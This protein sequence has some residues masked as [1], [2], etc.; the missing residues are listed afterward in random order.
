MGIELFEAAKAGDCDQM[1]YWLDQGA[2]IDFK[3]PEWKDATPLF[4]AV[5]SGSYAAVSLLVRRGAK[6][7]AFNHDGWG[8]IHMASKKLL[9]AVI[10]MLLSAGASSEPKCLE[11]AQSQEEAS[12]DKMKV[13]SLLEF[14]ST[15][16][17]VH[18]QYSLPTL[19]AQEG[20]ER[21]L[22]IQENLLSAYVSLDVERVR[23]L[24]ESAYQLDASFHLRAPITLRQVVRRYGLSSERVELICA[25][26][27]KEDLRDEDDLLATCA[28]IIKYAVEQGCPVPISQLFKIIE[29][30]QDDALSYELI[31][32]IAHRI[33]QESAE[34]LSPDEYRKLNPLLNKLDHPAKRFFNGLEK[35][36]VDLDGTVIKAP[37][38]NKTIS[39][40]SK[41]AGSSGSYQKPAASVSKQLHTVKTTHKN[42]Q[43]QEARVDLSSLIDALKSQHKSNQTHRQRQALPSFRT[44]YGDNRSWYHTTYRQVMSF[45]KDVKNGEALKEDDI[46]RYLP[47]KFLKN[48]EKW[49]TGGTPTNFFVDRVICKIFCVAS[50]RQ[51]LNEVSFDK[52]LQCVGTMSEVKRSLFG[53]ADASCIASR[54]IDSSIWNKGYSGGFLNSDIVSRPA[55]RLNADLKVVIEPGWLFDTRRYV[56]QDTQVMSVIESEIEA[57]RSE[58]MTAIYHSVLRK[59][60]LLTASGIEIV[61]RCLSSSNKNLKKMASKT[62]DALGNADGIDYQSLF[63]VHLSQLEET[64]DLE[65]IEELLF[66]LSQPMKNSERASE[67]FNEEVIL[68]I[69]KCLDAPRLNIQNKLSVLELINEYM[70]LSFIR[71]L[72]KSHLD[73]L[74]KIIKEIGSPEITEAGLNILFIQSSKSKIFPEE[75]V[76]ALLSMV[77]G[78]NPRSQNLLVMLL[79]NLEW[80]TAFDF[81]QLA[82]KLLESSVA[83]QDLDGI[84]FVPR[85]KGNQ[86]SHS[87]DMLVAK[88]IADALQFGCERK[89][90]KDTLKYLVSNVSSGDKRARPFSARALYLA[91]KNVLIDE[92]IDL[93]LLLEVQSS[94][95]DPTPDIAVY[96]TCFYVHGLR[97]HALSKALL[98]LAHL[99]FLAQVYVTDELRLNEADYTQQV[100]A[101][102][103][104]IIRQ[105][106]SKKRKLEDSI[107]NIFVASFSLMNGSE[108]ELFK[109]WLLILH[110]QLV[111]NQYAVPESVIE[112]LENHLMDSD[113]HDQV[114]N[115]LMAA[116]RNRQTVS[117][118]TLIVFKDI[119]FKSEDPARRKFV[120]ECLSILDLHQD[121]PTS[122]FAVLEMEKAANAIATGLGNQ[123]EAWRLLENSVRVEEKLTLT[124]LDVLID[125]KILNQRALAIFKT[126]VA[127][128]QLLPRKVVERLVLKFEFESGQYQEEL[129]EIFFYLLRNHQDLP[130]AVFQDL[131]NTLGN[132]EDNPEDNPEGDPKISLSMR[133]KILSIFLLKGQR[134][135]LLSFNVMN[136]LVF[137][138]S[139]KSDDFFDAAMRQACLDSIGTML[140][141]IDPCE[142]VLYAELFWTVET[143]L[144][145]CL[146]DPQP[147]SVRSC[148]QGLEILKAKQGL[149]PQTIE[150]LIKLLKTSQDKSLREPL[151]KL[152]ESDVLSENQ[153]A[154]LVLFCLN[155]DSDEA[156][157]DQCVEHAQKT[158]L[159][160][161]N[162]S[163]ISKIIVSREDL[164]ERALELLSRCN[165]LTELPADLMGHV[166]VLELSSM[167]PEVTHMAR[168]ILEKMLPKVGP[169]DLVLESSEE[170]LG[171]DSFIKSIEEEEITLAS[172]QEYKSRISLMNSE[173]LNLSLVLLIKKLRH[174]EFSESMSQALLECFLLALDYDCKPHISEQVFGAYLDCEE[175]YLRDLAFEGFMRLKAKGYTSE[176]FINYCRELDESITEETGCPIEE[177][178]DLEVLHA[179]ASV[180][181]LS[182]PVGLP[183]KDWIKGLIF[184]DWSERWQL[185][186]SEKISLYQAWR[187]KEPFF[188]RPD[189]MLH[190]LHRQQSLT[191]P[192]LMDIIQYG[193][194][195]DERVIGD[196][197]ASPD[198]GYHSLR[199]LWLKAMLLK[200]IST[201][202]LSLL[203]KAFI[204]QFINEMATQ[205]RPGVAEKL[206]TVFQASDSI[207]ELN[208]LLDFAKRY[209]ISMHHLDLGLDIN[210]ENSVNLAILK[211]KLQVKLL[212]QDF[213]L[214]Y[215]G[216]LEVIFESL[217]SHGWNFDQLQE[218]INIC[219]I[220]DDAMHQREIAL[221]HVLYL[222]APY[223]LSFR[224]YV[225]IKEIFEKEDCASWIKLVNL[226]VVAQHFSQEPAM[227]TS[228]QLLRDFV[229]DNKEDSF[230]FN[231][232]EN[233]LLADIDFINNPHATVSDFTYQVNNA[234]GLS[235]SRVFSCELPVSQWN[236]A[237]ILSWAH[238]V[239]ACPDYFSDPVCLVQAIAV[240]KQTNYLLTGFHLTNTQILACLAALKSEEGAGRFL[241][242]Q[243]GEGKTLIISAIAILKALQGKK[244][245][246]ITSSPVEAERCAREQKSLYGLFGISV[247]DN[248]DRAIYV[249]GPKKCYHSDV[250][251]GEISQ[252]QF[253]TLR[254]EYGLLGTKAGRACEEMV[255][256][257]VDSL[258]I[259]D[260]TKIAKL[261]SPVAGIDQLQPAYYF[262]YRR[263]NELM[264]GQPIE[265]DAEKFIEKNLRD[266]F[267][268]L[269]KQGLIQIPVNFEE[270][271]EKQV[272]HWIKNALSACVEF[273]EEAHYLVRDQR[274]KPVAFDSNGTVQ[275]STYWGDGLHQFLQLKHE[276]QLTSESSTTNFL[277]NMAY[278]KRYGS[279]MCGLTG[280][281][282]SKVARKNLSRVYKVE[283]IEVPSARE[284]QYKEL[285]AVLSSNKSDWMSEVCFETLHELKK[286]RGVLIICKTID[287]VTS[288]EAHIKRQCQSANIKTYTMDG[289]DQ[290]KAI[291]RILPGDII[292]A[293][294]LAGRGFDIKADAINKFGG[295]HVISTYMLDDRNDNQAKY[296][297]SRKGN[298][299]TGRR[300]LNT[301]TLLSN[302]YQPED[303]TS[304]SNLEAA[305][306]RYETLQLEHLFGETLRRVDLKDQLF[307]KFLT[308]ISEIRLDI[309][310]KSRG[311]VQDVI[312]GTRALLS[313][314]PPSVYETTIVAAIEE[315]WA[316]FLKD[317][318]D[319]RISPELVRS[320]YEAFEQRIREQYAAGTVIQNPCH[321]I[322]LGNDLLANGPVLT[323][324]SGEA[325]AHFKAAIERDLRASAGAFIGKAWVYLKSRASDDDQKNYKQLAIE[326]FEKAMKLLCD[327]LACLHNLQILMQDDGLNEN[328][329]LLKQLS[330]KVGL[331]GSHIQ[332]LEAAID[333]I[334]RSQRLMTLTQFKT[335]QDTSPG[336][337][338]RESITTHDIEKQADGSLKFPLEE[339]AKYAV[340]FHDLTAR[341]DMGFRDQAINTISSAFDGEGDDK[342]GSHYKGI[343]LFVPA[344]VDLASMQDFLNPNIEFKQLSKSTAL[345]KL[346]AE[347]SLLNRM[348]GGLFGGSSV[349]VSV[350]SADATIQADREMSVSEAIKLVE[351][352]QEDYQVS[353]SF[354]N[355][356]ERVKSV[357]LIFRGLS[358]EAASLRLQALHH[359][360]VHVSL[361]GN[362]LELL[363][364]IQEES[365]FAEL[366]IIEAKTEQSFERAYKRDDALQII[367]AS[368]S[369]SVSI[370]LENMDQ[371]T[372]DY[373]FSR[374]KDLNLDL[375]ID[376]D[377]RD[378]DVSKSLPGLKEGE[379]EIHFSKLSKDKA[380]SLI[381]QLRKS[382]TEFTTGFDGLSGSQVSRLIQKTERAQEKE[383]IE[384]SAVRSLSTLFAGN[385]LPELELAELSNRGLE[386]ILEVNERN[387]I[388][389]YSIATVC[390]LATIQ[391][392]AGAALMISGFGASVGMGLITEGIADFAT[393]IKAGYTRHFTWR[394][395]VHQKAISLVIAAATMG[396]QS[397]KNAGRAVQNIAIG[398]SETVLAQAGA[399]AAESGRSVGQTLVQRTQQ[400]KSVVFPYMGA[401]VAETGAREVLNHAVNTLSR[402]CFQNFKPKIAQS[403]YSHVEVKFCDT[404]LKKLM[405]KWHVLDQIRANKALSGQIEFTI[406]NTM[407][408]KHSFWLKQWNAVGLPLVQGI[409]SAPQYLGSRFSMGLRVLGL[410]QGSTEILTV[411][412]YFHRHVL[413]TLTTIDRES[414]SIQ[415]L[416][417][418]DC[419][420]TD[421]ESMAIATLLKSKGVIIDDLS[422]DIALLNTVEFGA[423]EQY[424]KPVLGFLSALARGME[425]VDLKPT[426][427][428]IA[429]LMADHLIMVTE[430]QL[431]APV[432]SYLVASGVNSLS[433]KAQDAMI[434]SQLSS[435]IDSINGELKVL[436]EKGASLTG[437]DRN[438]MAAMN[439]DLLERAVML[440]GDSRLTYAGLTA[441][442]AEKKTAAHSRC[443][444]AFYAGAESA[445]APSS[446]AEKLPSDI[447]AYVDGVKNKE[448]ADLLVMTKMKT[449]NKINLKIVDESYCG[450]QQDR[451]ENIKLAVFVSG[452]K[453]PETNVVGI[454][455]WLLKDAEG[456]VLMT[457][458]EGNDCGY[459]VIAELT[460]KSIQDLRRETAESIVRDQASFS[461]AIEARDW[462]VSHNPQAANDLLFMGGKK[463]QPRSLKLGEP[464]L[465]IINDTLNAAA[466]VYDKSVKTIGDLD[467]VGYCY[468]KD[469]DTHVGIYRNRNNGNVIVAFE[470]T[471]FSS[472]RSINDG[473]PILGGGWPNSTQIFKTI[474]S[475]YLNDCPHGS[476]IV[477][478]GHSKGALL[479]S[480]M[481]DA[482]G[483]PA[484]VYDNPG[485][486]LTGYYVHP[487]SGERRYIFSQV[488]SLQAGS[489]IERVGG[490]NK[491]EV[492]Y[493]KH[494]Q[495]SHKLKNIRKDI[496]DHNSNKRKI[497]EKLREKFPDLCPSLNAE[498]SGTGEVVANDRNNTDQGGTSLTFFN[499]VISTSVVS[500]LGVL[501]RN[502]QKC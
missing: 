273:Q 232:V 42:T 378:I 164:Q 160:A 308:L 266:Y 389:W 140:E 86:L 465:G 186:S 271:V 315:P 97:Q 69:I 280:T 183:R 207:L 489:V 274:V 122:V 476:N 68:R 408:P 255:G 120:F 258:L 61:N 229:K 500:Q 219:L 90:S 345:E 431:V 365:Q 245:D 57:M 177:P 212:S 62:L 248:L 322:T 216:K 132:P 469:Y 272:S 460:G 22:S 223:D 35:V 309:R 433:A 359:Q 33:S 412:D 263:L 316:M 300:I 443:S 163:R 34:A 379:A 346:K 213:K 275:N 388:P 423:Y 24:I 418:Q 362:K 449:D 304:L 180:E 199:L 450:T 432:T 290:E 339:T 227:K 487:E 193:A 385:E 312:D 382:D 47:E 78:L 59:P 99:S 425:S 497:A 131:E 5:A 184:S 74:L 145:D 393:A 371:K 43:Q 235:E 228:G 103:L 331:L 3:N 204:D 209:E 292:I 244:V 396:W 85:T 67:L 156:Y 60:S 44:G 49:F 159:L 105:E 239:K 220:K 285:P 347:K 402:F 243:T 7:S 260:S 92:N 344:K 155:S 375:I 88:I 121:L 279:R 104:E 87:I 147:H 446:P 82:F 252:F 467:R 354:V 490:D 493:L 350:A 291:E 146:N 153:R 394:D 247:S 448:P 436:S 178:R 202:S 96:S 486:G 270:F 403:I 318:D 410:L 430:S 320:E 254:D 211:N 311:V 294:S 324:T 419:G 6:V 297:T 176:Y 265:G 210:S 376:L 119:L 154:L 65:E 95:V 107:F 325:M 16:D 267:D 367:E 126:V 437:A 151:I 101:D 463:G 168:K 237:K 451:E 283:C 397:I 326:S 470:G 77:R 29:F 475:P 422:I 225:R 398:Q 466:A 194:S 25:D 492:I 369:N 112:I 175:A 222:L 162:F 342:L 217:L 269:V 334:K 249:R 264:V 268:D 368:K 329:A 236:H 231:F 434:R 20:E 281:L 203:D 115:L 409:L 462:L 442:Y 130:R 417:E 124:V 233:G 278:V 473:S 357:D 351:A 411:I 349:K 134:G 185:S 495:E 401:T 343:R 157:L 187:I 28:Q 58:A 81:N 26:L 444:M 17:P 148:V 80:K 50:E 117:K 377:I 109:Q 481:S 327:E 468:V 399:G 214:D 114:L 299:G 38:K 284:K 208:L 72:L 363:K 129:L 499:T 165:N 242:V 387:F 113:V 152:L 259:D 406:R 464:D 306:D 501:L 108:N 70:K 416:L 161:N 461:K 348:S 83:V 196:A 303:L 256:D 251:Y 498:N 111:L 364:L 226:E 64:D 84:Q 286:S 179:I 173:Q 447:A 23:E 445:Q 332:A 395:Y 46:D 36:L 192:E 317:F 158:E 400:L 390:S 484:I 182:F 421:I 435:E 372:M 386:F 480:V 454:G 353:L 427:S 89:V 374:C 54:M 14:A 295:M 478:T 174:T 63:M 110:Q 488:L 136:H 414:F 302:G 323:N 91:S 404:T 106:A 167:L 483:C 426:I 356:N 4:A 98:P 479:A 328:S 27:L 494:G 335:Y 13:T 144:I 288:L 169:D 12:P 150:A 298:L 170:I 333:R 314:V 438:E 48:S 39:R 289:C 51:A 201:S 191:F 458:S 93:D 135:D 361:S 262:L 383:E 172:I 52:L 337:M 250:V 79:A 171:L 321:H 138:F 137:L 55:E 485:C 71:G 19:N 30:I 37:I 139:R 40:S 94:T 452:E 428:S 142:D 307:L 53:T 502:P 188:K 420:L 340:Q 195:L 116:I 102:I 457:A 230:V 341:E 471:D 143:L 221:F 2:D 310:A 253:D 338:L 190:L 370:K 415:K 10:R 477:F 206:L 257:E 455:H 123:E 429:G 149:A 496:K 75:G 224:N 197:L 41:R 482:Y 205:C 336:A 200:K 8:P 56:Y 380:C 413:S 100:N 246:V 296:R 352:A 456:N 384:I 66:Q 240:I 373:L 238:A 11:I 141:K 301:Q 441:H 31:W 440:S 32:A 282:G 407:D 133:H 166:R 439:D 276:V 360:S 45:Y 330:I 73:Q 474:L 215:K 459:A 1:A 128:N 21:L 127:N 76:I 234:G 391:V 472:L 287:E 293:T 9:P 189:F 405:A 313:N 319:E 18:T 305:R 355:A 424:K 118:K 181:H 125:G 491:G 198:F 261:S 218:L 453:D 277:S 15:L 241:Q 392:A 381:S 366:Q 358:H